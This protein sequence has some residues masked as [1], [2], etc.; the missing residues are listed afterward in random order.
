MVHNYT[1]ESKIQRMSILK[2]VVLQILMKQRTNRTKFQLTNFL[3]KVRT[4]NR[5]VKNK[6]I[7]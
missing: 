5:E 1:K 2:N 7:E 6:I 4:H 3:K